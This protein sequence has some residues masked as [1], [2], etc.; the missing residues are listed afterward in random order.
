[1]I[2]QCV[3][4]QW[5]SSSS[6]ALLFEAWDVFAYADS[7]H[8]LTADG[9]ADA[10]TG[11]TTPFSGF[12][13]PTTSDFTIGAARAADH[14]GFWVATVPGYWYFGSDQPRL[15][16]I[17]TDG[18]ATVEATY[19]PTASASESGHDD[20]ILDGYGQLFHTTTSSSDT[21]I[22]RRSQITGVSTELYDELDGWDV[23]LDS[24]SGL[25]T[26]P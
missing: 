26:G 13:D 16:H 18:Q 21:V 9:V 6:G 14:G 20:W 1:M 19:P 24:G 10:A 11:L 5:L 7:G 25:L 22:V 8:A 17:T 15:W 3:G 4:I 23:T 2:V 12:L